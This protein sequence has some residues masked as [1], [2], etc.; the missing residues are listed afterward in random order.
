[1]SSSRPSVILLQNFSVSLRRLG[2]I[3]AGLM[4]AGIANVS[5][6]KGIDTVGRLYFRNYNTFGFF[7]RL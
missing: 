6:D 3:G 5:V 1:M 4:G 7:W 2:V